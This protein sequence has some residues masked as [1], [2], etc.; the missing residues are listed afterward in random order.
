MCVCLYTYVCM[1]TYT[2]M[3]MCIYVYIYSSDGCCD[4]R[5][6][7]F[8][9]RSIQRDIIEQILF[10][11]SGASLSLWCGQVLELLCNHCVV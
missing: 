5:V 6:L 7:P 2:Y 11:S 8:C 10:V 4:M 3:Y 1:Y 9:H